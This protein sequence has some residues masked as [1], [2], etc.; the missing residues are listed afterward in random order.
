MS[1]LYTLTNEF[2]N[3]KFQLEEMELDQE[4][5][6]NT[7]ESLDLP[8]EQKAENIIK[9]SK[10]IEALAEMRKAEAKRLTELANADLK[11]AQMLL[12][13][14]D[15]SLRVMGKTKLQAGIFQVSYRKGSEVVEVDENHI[16]DHIV[17]DGVRNELK[18][19]QPKKL[20]S[21]TELKALIKKGAQIDG[22]SLVR[23]SDNMVIK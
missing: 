20:I 4:T 7:L 14:L 8:I 11:K 21:K 16:P 12:E 2:L 9:L 13:N 17:I 18:I 23:K 22:V 10:N 15:T 1:S 6:A 3:I 19:P 5:I